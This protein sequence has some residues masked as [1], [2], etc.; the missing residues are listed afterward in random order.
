[1]NKLKENKK[2]QIL[3]DI[4]IKNGKFKEKILDYYYKRWQYINKKL[5][6]IENANIIQHF[7]LIRVKN[8]IAI[9]KWKKLYNLLKN[10]EQTNHIK[11]FKNNKKIYIFKKIS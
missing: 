1:M 9:N 5:N 8:R 7:C 3:K 2:S 6:Q 4:L 11:D 10:K